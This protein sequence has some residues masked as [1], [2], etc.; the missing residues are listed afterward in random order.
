MPP[1]RCLHG[2]TAD[3]EQCLDER[4]TLD[5]QATDNDWMFDPRWE[6]DRNED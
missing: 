5:A 1:E 4:E 6:D 2:V 3:C